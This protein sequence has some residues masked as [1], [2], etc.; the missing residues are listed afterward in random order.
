MIGMRSARVID[1]KLSRNSLFC[2]RYSSTALWLR[3]WSEQGVILVMKWY[4]QPWLAA[5]LRRT[6]PSSSSWIFKFPVTV[7]RVLLC[8][9]EDRSPRTSAKGGNEGF[10]IQDGE[11]VNVLRNPDREVT[12]GHS[13]SA[14][15][16]KMQKVKSELYSTSACDYFEC[17]TFLKIVLSFPGEVCRQVHRD[18]YPYRPSISGRC[19]RHP[20][21]LCYW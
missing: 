20:R 17:P 4:L 13:I 1:Q 21:K 2:I 5:D 15:E 18:H 19:R 11:D 12:D 8:I 7:L 14:R 16:E 9:S 3:I 10:E 6:S